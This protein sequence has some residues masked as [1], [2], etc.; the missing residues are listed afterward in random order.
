MTREEALEGY[1]DDTRSMSKD[2]WTREIIN[3]IYDDIESRIC[4]NC[5]YYKMTEGGYTCS[6]STSYQEPDYGCNKFIRK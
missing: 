5:V 6:L 3:E 2:Y 4:S 1:E